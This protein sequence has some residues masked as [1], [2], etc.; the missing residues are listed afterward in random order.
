MVSLGV[1]ASLNACATKL[2]PVEQIQKTYSVVS[3]QLLFPISVDENNR[4]FVHIR[5]EEGI[6]S[7]VAANKKESHIIR[8]LAAELA[9]SPESH[10]VLLYG[11][12]VTTYQEFIQGI[13]Y[14]IVAVLYYH[15]QSERYVMLQTNYQKGTREALRELDLSQIVPVLAEQA[16][17]LLR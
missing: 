8:R 9:K 13:D 3:G 14:S 11:I 7:G 2:T 6:V 5:T 16:K 1:F 15:S 4:L 17:K 12:K 10:P